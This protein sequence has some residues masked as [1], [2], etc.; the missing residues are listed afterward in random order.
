MKYKIHTS[1]KSPYSLESRRN[2][3]LNSNQLGLLTVLTKGFDLSTNRLS[4][5]V[6]SEL[7]MQTLMQESNFLNDNSLSESIPYSSRR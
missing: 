7:G 5:T 3:T 1:D 2:S 6:P 4:G